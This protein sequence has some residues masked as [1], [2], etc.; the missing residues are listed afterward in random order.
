MS[1]CKK[2][3][4]RLSTG[5]TFCTKCGAK[6]TELS[7]KA[8]HAPI[9]ETPVLKEK[10]EKREGH[11]PVV[12]KEKMQLPWKLISIVVIGIAIIAGLG[13]GHVHMIKQAD[14]MKVIEKFDVAVQGENANAL[15]EMMN[16]GQN[17]Y[18]VSEE[19]AASYIEYLTKE[20]EDYLSLLEDLNF[21]TPYREGAEPVKDSNG[22]H[23]FKLEKKAEKKWFLYNQYQIV[24][25]PTEL[26]ISSN[27]DGA[28]VW[29]NGEELEEKTEQNSFIKAGY[30]FPGEHVLKA[31]FEGEYTD[32]QYEGSIDF[33]LAENN[34]LEAFI[35]FESTTVKLS[36]N[37]EDAILFVNG[38]STGK[39]IGDVSTFGPIPTDGSVSLHAERNH[40]GK[41]VK[42]E[43]IAIYEDSSIRFRLEE[44][45][46][47]TE[48]EMARFMDSYFSTMVAS[49][50][51]RDALLT[52][53]VMDVEGKAY[54]E[55]RDYLK[56]LEERGI[57]EEYLSMELV[58][59]EEVEGGYRVKTNEDYHISYGDGTRKYKSFVSEF[60][61]SL[62]DDGLR[63]HTLLSTTETESRDL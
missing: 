11:N 34:Q 17:D 41:T 33:S 7:G 45:V 56:V 57:T 12:V 6:V 19:A 49:I 58:D 60:F 2:C 43:P 24:F 22:N 3:S 48:A 47:I 30:L 39:E 18:H 9:K 21:Q 27:L 16:E 53:Y 46:V 51:A 31:R 29:L 52:E 55:H 13:A 20:K 59:N 38:K 37:Y 23:M 10:E 8:T 25:Y 35:E 40:N 62:L 1:F 44:P 63:V 36:S 42:S 14:P 26:K 15:A 61:V 54:Q 5:Q 28:T 50:N 4:N 32:F